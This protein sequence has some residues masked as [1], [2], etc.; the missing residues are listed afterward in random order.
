MLKI[1]ATGLQVTTGGTTAAAAIPN[2]SS[3]NR[4]R[5]VRLQA[6]ANCYVRP[7]VSTV[8][9]T[10][11]D[12]LLSP[13]EAVVLDVNGMTHIAHIQEAVGAKFNISPLENAP[14]D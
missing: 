10:V 11:N 7:G 8:V 1:A 5:W 3:G 12:V 6:L 9:A 2:D 14:T 13:N 4:A